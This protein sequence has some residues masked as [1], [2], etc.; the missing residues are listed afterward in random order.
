MAIFGLSG[1]TPDEKERLKSTDRLFSMQSFANFIF[2]YGMLLGPV[3]LL[4]LRSDIMSMISLFVHGLMKKDSLHGFLKKWLRNLWAKL[5]FD[6]LFGANKQKNLWNELA[7]FLG[8]VKKC[9]CLLWF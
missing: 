6:W 2:N 9:L 1:R 3:A 5:I 7:I 8:V 4:L